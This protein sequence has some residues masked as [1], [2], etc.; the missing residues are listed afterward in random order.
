MW[1]VNGIR[2]KSFRNWY[3]AATAVYLSPR[4]RV[5]ALSMVLHG[6]ETW[7]SRRLLPGWLV[8]ELT[9]RDDVPSPPSL[10]TVSTVP[11]A[12]LIFSAYWLLEVQPAGRTSTIYGPREQNASLPRSLPSSQ[13]DGGG[14]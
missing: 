10:S 14:V 4:R 5:A 2:E 3:S 7:S 13:H 11:S 1:S 12:P 6:A 9:E 8:R